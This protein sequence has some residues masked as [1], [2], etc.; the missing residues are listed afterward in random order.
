MIVLSMQFIKLLFNRM[1]VLIT[2]LL[3][4][5]LVSSVCSTETDK[6]TPEQK[7][8][9]AQWLKTLEIRKNEFEKEAETVKQAKTNLPTG[10]GTF[11]IYG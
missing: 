4:T 6:L 10:K 2:S 3:L 8:A 7:T 9:L 1:K 5:I 11:I